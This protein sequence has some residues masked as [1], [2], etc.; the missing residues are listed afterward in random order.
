MEAGETLVLD[1]EAV[2]DGADAAGLFL[3]G[4]VAAGAEGE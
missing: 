4:V 3:V 1:L 2:I